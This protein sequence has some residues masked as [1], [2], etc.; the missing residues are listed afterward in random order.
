MDRL[1]PQA[2]SLPSECLLH[3]S[4]AGVSSA[5]GWFVEPEHKPSLEG[6]DDHRC[7]IHTQNSSGTT[8]SGAGAHVEAFV[9]QVDACNARV[10]QRHFMAPTPSFQKGGPVTCPLLN[11]NPNYAKQRAVD[12][13]LVSRFVAFFANLFGDEFAKSGDSVCEHKSR[14]RKAFSLYWHQ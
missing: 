6:L 8:G 1:S 2:G 13:H 11:G 7:A 3:F 10:L 4:D 12:P 14:A 5:P 9:A